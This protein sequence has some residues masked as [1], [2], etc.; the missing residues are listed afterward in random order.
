MAT[1]DRRSRCDVDVVSGVFMLVRTEAVDEVG[2]M[3]EAYFVY[4]EETG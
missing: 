2:L 3:D 4:V 1:W